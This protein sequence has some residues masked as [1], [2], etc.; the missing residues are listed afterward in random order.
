MHLV[1]KGYSGDLNIALVIPS[2]GRPETLARILRHWAAQSVPLARRVV[3]VTRDED[4]KGVPRELYDDLLIGPVGLCR[5]RNAALD[6]LMTSNTD[7]VIFADDDYVPS[8]H[9]V[10]GVGELFAKHDDVVVATG[11]MIA[12]GVTTGGI[13]Y[14]EAARLVRQHDCEQRVPG[15]AEIRATAG[16][17]GC[18]M[19]IRWTRD[20][21][22]RCDE[23]LPLYGWQEDIDYSRRYRQYGAIVKAN[24]FAGVHMGVRGSRSS[25]LPLG[26]SQVMNPAY[27]VLKGT[28]PVLFGLELMLRNFMANMLGTLRGDALIDRT[29]RLKGNFIGFLHLLRGR[30]TPE[31]VLTLSKPRSG[32]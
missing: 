2:L 13:D 14:E 18:N 3:S 19:A 8:E 4:V 23:R 27:L 22:V 26:Y 30:V 10:R 15:T 16:G 20:R 9:F 17:Y 29:G 25:G 5:Q 7:I 12:D 31:Y 28:M 24:L 11:Q 1:E 32:Q 6:H 21:K